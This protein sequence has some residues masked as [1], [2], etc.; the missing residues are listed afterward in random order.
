[1][2]IIKGNRHHLLSSDVLSSE[3]FLETGTLYR[4][5]RKCLLYQATTTMLPFLCCFYSLPSSSYVCNFIFDIGASDMFPVHLW[6]GSQT[7]TLQSRP[8]PITAP[9]ICT[10]RFVTSMARWS[11]MDQGEFFSVIRVLSLSYST[12]RTHS[13]RYDKSK[14]LVFQ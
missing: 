12:P 9:S 8:G 4:L 10:W 14:L 7:C 2:L 1:M 5:P 3:H 13:A 6:Q 11:C